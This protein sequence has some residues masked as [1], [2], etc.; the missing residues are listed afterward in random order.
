MGYII[1]RDIPKEEARLDMQIFQIKGGFRGFS[2]VPAGLHF[3][4]VRESDSWISCWC[5][6]DE[7]DAIIKVFDYQK[8]ALLD[9]IENGEHFRQLALSHAMD[10]VLIPCSPDAWLEWR[11]LSPHITH[12]CFPP[13]LYHEEPPPPPD[14]EAPD[15]MEQMLKQKTRY[16]QAFSDTHKGNVKSFLAEFEFAFL[17]RLVD[18]DDETAFKRWRYLVQSVYGVGEE[19]IKANP[20]LFLDLVDVLICQMDLL[21]DDFFKEDSFVCARAIHLAEDLI[22][23]EIEKAVKKGEEFTSYLEKRGCT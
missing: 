3:V 17:R 13:Q 22:D 19:R 8:K 1:L 23:S 2:A 9:D 12:D 15:F 21:P 18:Q 5:L 4:A 11:G 7:N 14:P 16:D 20:D 6:L 10:H